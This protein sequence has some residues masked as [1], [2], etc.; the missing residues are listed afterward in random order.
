MKDALDNDV[1]LEKYKGFVVLIV[2]IATRCD[3]AHTNYVK[4]MELKRKYENAGT[5][6]DSFYG[7]LHI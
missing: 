3:L 4:L 1:N 6:C 7:L 2:N 5:L